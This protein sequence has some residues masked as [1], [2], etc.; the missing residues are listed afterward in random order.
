MNFGVDELS[1][2]SAHFVLIDFDFGAYKLKP[3]VA[4]HN[5]KNIISDYKQHPFYAD[6]LLA[7]KDIISVNN[8]PNN[9]VY[10]DNFQTTISKNTLRYEFDRFL[11][12]YNS[13]NLQKLK[14]Y[15]FDD[16]KINEDIGMIPDEVILKSN[17]RQ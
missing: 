17:L 12:F 13:E 8:F 6:A 9:G 2:T 15:A 4:T 10:V 11:K 5:V 14:G 7:V 16:T 3:I 1:T